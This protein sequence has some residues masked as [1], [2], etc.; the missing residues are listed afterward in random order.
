[1]PR[2]NLNTAVNLDSL[3]NAPVRSRDIQRRLRAALRANWRANTIGDTERVPTNS[4][5]AHSGA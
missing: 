2:S 4:A 3:A 1:M 5:H